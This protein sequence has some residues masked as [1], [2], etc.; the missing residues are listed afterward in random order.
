MIDAKIIEDLA[1]K[2]SQLVPPEMKKMHL[3]MESQFK[4]VLQS[5]LGKLELVTRE[6]FDVQTKVLQKT[7]NKLEELEK[8]VAELESKFNNPS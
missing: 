6:E 3:E 4:Q 5:Q 1:N 8:Q 2:M 7:R